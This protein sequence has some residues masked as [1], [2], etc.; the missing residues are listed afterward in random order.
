MFQEVKKGM[1]RYYSVNLTARILPYESHLDKKDK[2][3][4]YVDAIREEDRKF[5]KLVQDIMADDASTGKIV[6]AIDQNAIEQHQ[7]NEVALQLV[8][9]DISKMVQS[10]DDQVDDMKTQ[11]MTIDYRVW[12]EEPEAN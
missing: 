9:S 5:L 4:Q 8:S 12:E 3:Q 10:F 2:L 1:Y 11:S 6:E 7:K